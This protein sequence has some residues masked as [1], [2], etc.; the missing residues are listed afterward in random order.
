[1]AGWGLRFLW[2]CRRARRE[3]VTRT[4]TELAVW[5]RGLLR[6]LIEATGI[7]FDYAATGSLKIFR[8]ADRLEQARAAA[9]RAEPLGV[10]A[11]VLDADGAVAQEPALAA[12]RDELAGGIYFAGDAVGD[13]ARFTRALGE[14]I[15]GAGARLCLGETVQRLEGSRDGVTGVV[16]DFGVHRG[17]AYL[18]ANGVDA[19]ALARPLGVGL[20]IEPVKG[21]SATLALPHAIAAPTVP[22]IDEARQVVMARLGD[23][24]RIAGLAELAGIDRRIR[25][26]AVERVMAAGLANVPDLA[27]RLDRD[28]AQYWACLRPVSA[29]GAPLLGATRV[30]NLFVNTGAG[31]L[32][33]T[34]ATGASR[35][36]ADAVTARADTTDASV[37]PRRFRG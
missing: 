30:P 6:E 2:H 14:T 31:H 33:W 15:R 32:G 13:A 8:S 24:L 35:L 29:D 28:T 34:L 1:L 4:N 37:S 26:A 20:P 5:S 12:I 21:Y 18:L 23:R 7:D 19:P 25:P 11:R 27:D 22:L 16:T 9:A 17:D 10:A 3:A 36:A